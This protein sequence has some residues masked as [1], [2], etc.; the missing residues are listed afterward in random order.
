MT[1]T[2]MREASIS[3]PMFGNLTIN[4]PAYFTVFGRDI[5]WYGVILALAF[6]AA[7]LWCAHRARDFGIKEDDVYEEV[8]WLVPLGVVGCRIYYVIFQWDYYSKHLNE[9]IRV[10]DGGIAM[11]GGIIMGIIFL[12]IWTKK[13]HLSLGAV[14]DTDASGMLLAQSI[15]RWGNFM[16]REAFGAQTDIFCR[17]GLTNP[18]E[19]TIY[20]HPTFLYESIWTL[21]GFIALNIWAKKGHRKYDGQ[22]FIIYIMWYGLG[23]SWIEGLRTDSL[24][25]IPGVI[26]VSQM[27]AMASAAVMAVILIVQ[28]RRPHPPEKLFV[29]RASAAEPSGAGTE[30]EEETKSTENKEENHNV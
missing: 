30:A 25:L 21:A 16:N 20:V 14:L 17:M 2:M 23:R 6:L 15:G 18:G 19:Q 29:N 12:L 13:K 8:L 4:P 10:W 1:E 27:V 9:I 24:W 22:L 3:F 26:R 5:Y 7:L 11:Y 28:A